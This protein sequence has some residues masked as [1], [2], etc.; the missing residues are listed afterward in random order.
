V[1]RTIFTDFEAQPA[2]SNDKLV[3]L[4]KVPS[5][6]NWLRKKGKRKKVTKNVNM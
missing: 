3:F 2:V 4:Q 5:H 6:E 1:L